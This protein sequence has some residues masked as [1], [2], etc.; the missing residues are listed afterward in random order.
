MSIFIKLQDMEKRLQIIENLDKKMDKIEI[1]LEKII[2]QNEDNTTTLVSI[3]SSTG[4]MDHHISFVENVFDV[5]KYPFSSF[6]NLYYNKRGVIE[7]DI[8]QLKR[9]RKD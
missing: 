1:L 3:S 2:K 7:Q 8:S 5:V 4:N 9:I 6:L